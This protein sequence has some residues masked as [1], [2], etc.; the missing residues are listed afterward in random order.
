MGCVFRETTGYACPGCGLTTASLDLMRGDWREAWHVH[1][2]AP[3]FLA[4]MVL[5]AGVSLLPARAHD[6]A[7]MMVAA[8]ERR[9]GLSTMIGLGM[10]LYWIAR[11]PL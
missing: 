10:L 8:F 11:W 1:A 7:A 2:F 3:L 6:R 9:T 4:A 5:V